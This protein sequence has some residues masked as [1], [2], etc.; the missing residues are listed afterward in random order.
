[1]MCGSWSS[2]PDAQRAGLTVG[3]MANARPSALTSSSP[4]RP[5]WGAA[6]GP[7]GQPLA[8]GRPELAPGPRVLREI[9]RVIPHDGDL[10]SGLDEARLHAAPDQRARRAGLEAPLFHLAAGVGDLQEKPG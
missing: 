9:A 10:V 7:D 5:A 3:P 8:V 4:A 2:P 1:M 6:G